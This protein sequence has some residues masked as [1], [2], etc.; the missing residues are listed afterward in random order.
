MTT[1]LSVPLWLIRDRIHNPHHGYLP[2]SE[3]MIPDQ[4]C[5]LHIFT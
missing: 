3:Q 5:Q 1:D 4:Q 2:K